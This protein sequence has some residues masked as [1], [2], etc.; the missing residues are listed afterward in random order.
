MQLKIVAR[1]I[2]LSPRLRGLVERRLRFALGRF[3]TRLKG[4]VVCLRDSN[5]PRGGLG[6]QCRIEAKL[7]PRGRVH[8]EVTEMGIEKAVSAAADLIA[9]RVRRGLDRR[10]EGRRCDHHHLAPLP[11]A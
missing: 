1:N 8:V 9:R 5:G 7:H 2:D 11:E 4:V 6:D 10:L 3:G